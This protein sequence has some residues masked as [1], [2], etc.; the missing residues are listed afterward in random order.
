METK[1]W[2][3]E[4]EEV[5]KILQSDPKGLKED[6]RRKRLEN[7]G[8]NEIKGKEKTF[9][10]V[11]IKQ[12][13]NP[14]LIIL[15]I[16]IFAFMFLN[17]TAEAVVVFIIVILSALV[18]FFQEWK[19][20]NVM[21]ELKKFLIPK[22]IVYVDGKVLEIDS[23]LLVPGDIILLEAGMKV[24]ADAR[25]LESKELS[26]DES[27]LTGE[28]FP[29]SKNSKKVK[30]DTSLLERTCMI[31]AGTLVTS[32]WCKAVVVATGNSTE[33]GK[34]SRSIESVEIRSPLILRLSNFSKQLSIA[35]AAIS[36]FIFVAG[37]LR[38]YDTL[39]VFVASLSFAVALIPEIL[40]ATVTLALAFG[41]R[42]MAKRNA[43]VK[44]L[45][46]VETLGSVDVICT[47]KTGTLTQ[48]RMK[49]VKIVTENAEYDLDSNYDELKEK[50]DLK[51]IVLAGY[52]CNKAVCENGTCRGD[53]MEIALLEVALKMGINEEFTLIDEIPFDS[54]RKYMAVAVKTDGKFY[55]VVKGAPEVL[56]MMI[57]GKINLDPEK[58]AKSGMRVL[59]FAWKELE[60]FKGFNIFD[61]KNLDFL[62]YQC[63]IDPPRENVKESITKCKEAGI[64]VLMIT[65]DHPATASTVAR[66]VGIEGETI[67]GLELE[68]IGIENALKDY[69]VFART[70]PEQK[71]EIVKILRENGKIVA[72][73]GD[74]VND[75]PALKQADIGV[76]MGSGSE[77]AKEAGDMVLLDD[78]F[79]TIVNAIEV[80]RDV[81]RKLQ[82]IVAWL[83]PTNGGQSS[84]VLAAFLLGI[85]MPMTPIHI[86][87]INTI[88]SGLLGMMLVFE[89]MEEG[90]LKL[91]PTRE[92]I[93]NKRIVAR[94]AY[95]SAICLVVAYYLYTDIGKMSAA[96]NG[97]IFVQAWYLLTPYLE[98][99]F[100][101]VGFRNKFALLGIF[102]T[103]I[104]QLV[105]TTAGVMNLEPMSAYEWIKTILIA[106]LCF[107]A[108]E[109]EKLAASIVER[110]I[111]KS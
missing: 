10:E 14:L 19:S 36:M 9:I 89:K 42:E 79:S 92:E 58:Y 39:Y 30:E 88:T 34:I 8:P 86:L 40:P 110:T 43:L 68:K 46:A 45:P 72:V 56:K 95:V 54:K 63:F 108:V 70:T 107:F 27:I 41:V 25:I 12:F 18:G 93:I 76:A 49:V 65:G 104:I 17:F 87:W 1:W 66:W 33:M 15:V 73:T 23:R 84:I 55:V 11:F 16:S 31:Y 26:V 105:L 98:K 21:R 48:N 109:A 47:D 82:R 32:G 75:A 22:A 24:P 20:E 94:I 5:L 111:R 69:R 52:F 61:L 2:A 67:T 53:P 97:V 50:E 80:G 78:S 106:S 7:F 60:N 101:K 4:N 83:L 29:V 37:I 3:L 28:S 35:V 99:S 91:K 102:A 57:N 44:S 51:R 38:G 74:G 100:F 13:K 62:G 59:A 85:S 6:E 71:L 81:F 103:F 64:E 96:V 90:L 77:V